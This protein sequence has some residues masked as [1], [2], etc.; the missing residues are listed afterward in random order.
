MIMPSYFHDSNS[1]LPQH[2]NETLPT[3]HM[4]DYLHVVMRH[5]QDMVM[6]GYDH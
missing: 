1:T 6:K 2:G 5:Y 4:F 3:V